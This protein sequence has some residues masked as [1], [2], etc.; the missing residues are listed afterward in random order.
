MFRGCPR[1]AKPT[2]A[3]S[4]AEGPVATPG[5]AA[6]PLVAL[7]PLDQSDAFVRDLVKGLSASPP[8]AAW[9]AS[10]ALVR[11]FTAVVENI[12]NGETPAPHLRLLAP[13]QG[14]LA[15]A[16]RGRQVIDPRSYEGYTPFADTIASLDAAGCARAYRVL[17]PLFDAAYRDLGHPEGGL[18]K[19]LDRAIG[20]LLETPAP[21]GEVTVIPVVRA[22]VVYEY[23]DLN[24]ESLTPAQKQ[25]LRIGPA[26][27]RKVQ[28]KLRELRDALKTVP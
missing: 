27:V 8:L 14:F 21:P 15:T 13:K 25:F 20:V 1:G 11:T 4:V 9:L 6:T 7:P 19:T 18:T 16:K 26:N 22:V 12:A 24:L 10:T 5:P 3:P 17:E 23:A 2:P 28:A